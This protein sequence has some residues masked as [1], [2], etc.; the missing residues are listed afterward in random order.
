MLC[1]HLRRRVHVVSKNRPSLQHQS[2]NQ[3][4]L[5]ITYT[6]ACEAAGSLTSPLRSPCSA[7]PWGARRTASSISPAFTATHMC[8][9][10]PMWFPCGLRCLLDVFQMTPDASLMPPTFSLFWTSEIHRR[11]QL[12]FPLLC[13]ELHAVS[14]T[15]CFSVSFAFSSRSTDTVS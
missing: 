6:A 15:L 2:T 7:R 4:L 11:P 1:K 8:L 5:L 3:A 10:M 9:V 12:R 13:C 14:S